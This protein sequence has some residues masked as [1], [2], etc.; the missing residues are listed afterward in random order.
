MALLDRLRGRR[1]EPDLT[2]AVDLPRAGS[3]G[4]MAVA[5]AATLIRAAT[6][7]SKG[8][9]AASDPL[10]RDPAD[11][12]PFGAG[13]PLQPSP[14]DQPRPDTGRPEPRIWQYPVSANLPGVTDRLIPW[15]VLRD[16]AQNIGLFRRCIEVRKS[17]IEGLEWDIMVSRDAVS[18]AMRGS[19]GST[20]IDVEQQLRDKY[21]PEIGRLR[22]FWE[23]PDR[24]NG[25]TFVEWCK[26]LLEE[27]FVLDA[28]AIYPRRTYGGQV[29]A[30]EVLDGSTIKPLLD[31]RGGRPL[32]PH[33][34]YQQILQGFPRG[35][36]VATSILNAQGETVLLDTYPADQLIYKRRNV[37]THTPYGLSAVEQALF[38]G[39][40]WLRRLDW[41]KSEYTEGALPPARIKNVQAGVEKEHWTPQKLAVYEQALNDLMSG[42]TAQRR[43]LKMLPLGW[44]TDGDPNSDAASKYQPDYDLFLIKLIG[45]HFETVSTELGFAET[46]GLG[47][48]GYHEGQADVQARRGT[49]PTI[50][51]LRGLFTD[52]MRTHLG[53]PVELEFRFLGEDNE[54]DAALDEVWSNRVQQGRATLNQDRD[55]TGQPRYDFPEADMPMLMTQRG[56]VFIDGAQEAAAAGT[57]IG[58]A[59]ANPMQDQAADTDGTQ[60]KTSVPGHYAGNGQERPDKKPTQTQKADELKQLRSFLAK[61]R[62][63]PFTADV[64]TK[65][66]VEQAGLDPTRVAFKA[67][68]ASPRR[69][70]RREGGM[71]RVPA[72]SAPYGDREHVIYRPGV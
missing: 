38:D 10:P 26:Q 49:N 27:H 47:S 64:L 3:N 11:L 69:P 51:W 58:P 67:D 29:W 5:D 54:D 21:E 15:K 68:D 1:T 46:G 65:A 12:N 2:K 16:A 52:L 71:D 30:L 45:G 61:D 44:E 62:P 63:R 39:E 13:W 53:A 50:M 22:A 19:P 32:P 72:L 24:G 57:L 20:K 6:E 14:I 48:A 70:R 60:P 18:M 55:R 35:E 31:H 7:G 28:V 43:N 36:F 42:Q 66:D 33:P 37:R 4:V 34:A 41:I 40:V 56:I 17:E 8:P 23:M 9:I 59:M 25:Y